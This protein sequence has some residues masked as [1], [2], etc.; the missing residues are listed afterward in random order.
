MPAPVLS[1][2][3]KGVIYVILS[4]LF[5]GL[6]GY[7]GINAL[8]FSG[9]IA[10]MLF[11]RFFIG[12]LFIG[13]FLA[14]QLKKIEFDWPKVAMIFTAAGIFYGFGTFA[15]FAA[16]QHLGTGIAMVLFFTY[17]AIVVFSNWL[18]YR[19][20]ITKGYM[21]AIILILLGLLLLVE[22]KL[23]FNYQG[24]ILSLISAA[25]YAFY[26][27]ASKKNTL[28]PLLAAWLVC[29]GCALFCFVFSL[30]N[31]AFFIPSDMH[32]WLHGLGLGIVATAVPILLLLQGLK[33][34][35]SE[36]AAMLGVLEPVFVA[37]TGVLLLGERLVFIQVLGIVVVLAGALLSLLSQQAGE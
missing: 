14:P 11:W 35:S 37:F 36:K 19:K 27:M 29:T 9:E 4:G 23:N 2:E 16:S 26:I 21:V 6:L 18:L 13:V 22:L 10:N 33:Y 31:D 3:I 7:F 17:P 30:A 12:A 28:H 32:F 25:G 1:N 8:F 34:I 20:K 15:F 5:Y 24:I